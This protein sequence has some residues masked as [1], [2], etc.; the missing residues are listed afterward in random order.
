LCPF[1]IDVSLDFGFNQET[2]YLAI[3][4]MDRYLSLVKKI[5]ATK[6]YYLLALTCFYLAAKFN[7]EL[8]EPHPLD[9]IASAMFPIEIADLKVIK[10]VHASDN[11]FL[12]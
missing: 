4:Y 7:E 12:N 6:Q 5:N 2:I 3:N 8:K 9:V 11:H 1:I 10:S